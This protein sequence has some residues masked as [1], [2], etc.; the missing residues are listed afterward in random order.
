[1]SDDA[2][3]NANATP[4]VSISHVAHRDD[5]TGV[6]LAQVRPIVVSPSADLFKTENGLWQVS[7]TIAIRETVGEKYFIVDPLQN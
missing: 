1:M 7:V 2:H 5:A 6:P 3:E 4:R